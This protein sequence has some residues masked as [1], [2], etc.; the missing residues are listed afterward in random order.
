MDID[1]KPTASLDTDWCG[2]NEAAR[3]LGVT[4]TAIRNRIK[5]GTLETRA[6]GNFGRLVRVPLPVP[7]TV[8]PTVDEPVIPTVTDTISLTVTGTVSVLTRHIERLEADIEALRQERA[9]ALARA[10]DR[11]A[12]A[13]QLDALQAVLD[14]ERKRIED[15]QTDRD[16]LRA[17]RDRWA[18]QAERLSLPAP[19]PARRGW[20]PFRRAG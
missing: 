15:L 3:R 7:S 9:D 4:A 14:V 11:D 18:A 10:A 19:A 6:N 12:I 5:R 1:P 2:V 20:W 8:T 17:D 16:N 13:A